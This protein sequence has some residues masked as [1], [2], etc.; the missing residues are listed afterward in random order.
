MSG[1]EKLLLGWVSVLFTIV[2]CI[3]VGPYVP[4]PA[5]RILHSAT[6]AAW[7]Q[8]AG[9]VAAMLSGAGAIAWQ[10][11]SETRRESRRELQ[12]DLRTAQEIEEL[13]VVAARQLKLL[14]LTLRHTPDLTS[15]RR[16]V[17]DAENELRWLELHVAFNET[18]VDLIPGARLKLAFIR[19]RGA[20]NQA[21][22]TYDAMYQEAHRDVFSWNEAREEALTRTAKTLDGAIDQFHAVA[23]I[24]GQLIV[25][26]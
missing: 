6:A 14:R 3:L 8:A 18:K 26:T 4:W 13:A 16:H 9:T 23:S 21:K 19:A 22:A 17:H 10:V 12:R 24:I 7:A 20:F 11:R 25:D 1:Y 2:L 5:H 15:V